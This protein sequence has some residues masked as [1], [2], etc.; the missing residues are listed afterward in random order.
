MALTFEHMWLRLV[1]VNMTAGR[2]IKTTDTIKHVTG[3]VQEIRHDIAGLRR[4]SH[5]IEKLLTDRRSQLLDP[6][7]CGGGGGVIGFRSTQ[8]NQPGGHVLADRLGFPRTDLDTQP[9]I[10]GDKLHGV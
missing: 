10:V 2:G 5:S 7:S 6:T 1:C 8:L 9:H 4:S 3:R